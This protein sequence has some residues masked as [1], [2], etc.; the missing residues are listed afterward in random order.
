MMDR[1][2]ERELRWAERVIVRHREQMWRR[3]LKKWIWD[4]ATPSWG[5][6]TL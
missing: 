2:S 5:D 4:R 3:W 1:V 6:W